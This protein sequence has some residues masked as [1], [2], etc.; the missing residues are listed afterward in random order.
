MYNNT[1]LEELFSKIEPDSALKEKIIRRME[2]KEMKKSASKSIKH[3]MVIAAC[4]TAAGLTTAFAAG[5]LISYF[6]SEKAVEL[7]D[8]QAL[9]EYNKEVGAS[10]SNLGYTL[11]IDNL[12]SDDNFIHVFYTVTKDGGPMT[13]DENFDLWFLYR[14]NGM[15]AGMG[16]NTDEYG[17]ISD[18]G[19]YKG[20][21][22]LSVADMDIPETFTL[23]MYS[24]NDS[25][26]AESV[27]EGDY[28]FR[29]DL[30][31]TSEDKEKLLYVSTTA[32]KSDIKT[33][34]IIK[35]VHKTFGVTYYD[36]QT[37]AK[38]N[39]EAEISKVI[40]SPFGN[41]LVVTDKCQGAGGLSVSGWALFDENGQ[42]LDIL[43]TGL[44]GATVD[45]IECTNSIEFLKANE[46]TKALK[47]VPAV[48]NSNHGD[49]PDIKH[50]IGTYPIVYKVNDYGSIVV[51]DIRISD[52]EIEIDYY[53]D[54]FS[55]YDPGF[56]LM[57][58]N[59]NNAEP[60]GKLGCL[61][62]T[63]VHHDTNSY[64]AKYSYDEYDI[65]GKK[66]PADESV[67]KENLEKKFTVLGAVEYNVFTL[68]YDNAIDIDLK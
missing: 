6:Q 38:K 53:K 54:G 18:D 65:H 35:E 36:D 52:G 2:E 68:D 61:L 34:S 50:N 26:K 47:L 7:T 31:L 41:Q 59:G 30:Q 55:P 56:R 28:L 48:Y 17:Y 42:N 39:G 9:A 1:D 19:S 43:N 29:K 5:G 58:S 21:V 15:L 16:N 67:S 62:T 40:L 44:S 11:T 27:F 20:V 64:T 57:D 37:D 25:K 23:E 45:G 13:E 4:V 32:E 3:L 63:V 33:K 66:I 46:K 10:A 14:I 60:G 8:M 22:K 24:A 51:T 49:L 12:A